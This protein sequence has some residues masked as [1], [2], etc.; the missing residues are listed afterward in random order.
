M[1]E[2]DEILVQETFNMFG[3]VSGAVGDEALFNNLNRSGFRQ[4]MF[5]VTNNSCLVPE[6]V[7]IHMDMTLPMAHYFIN[8]SHNTYLEGHQLYGKSSCEMYKHV[9]IAG[10]R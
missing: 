5:S 10:C 9:L 3:P 4:Y 2:V 6:R 7:P 1:A 8:S